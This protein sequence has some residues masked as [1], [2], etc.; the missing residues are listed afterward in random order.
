VHVGSTFSV[1]TLIN[2]GVPQSAVT[3]PLLFK[4]YISDQP[5]SLHTLVGDFANDKAILATS[6]DPHIPSPSPSLV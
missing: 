1:L 6:S 2:A 3:A 5:S 4:I